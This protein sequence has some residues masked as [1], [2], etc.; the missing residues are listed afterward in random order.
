M[1]RN[2]SFRQPPNR[3]HGG[4]DIRKMQ[5]HQLERG[6]RYDIHTWHVDVNVGHISTYPT[7]RMQFFL[8]AGITYVM[9]AT[10]GIDCEFLTGIVD[11]HAT[12]HV[13]SDRND[14]DPHI[15][16]VTP[17]NGEPGASA[18]SVLAAMADPILQRTGQWIRNDAKNVVCQLCYIR[19]ES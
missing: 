6:W 2:R 3:K 8:L 11:D 5:V 18:N 1:S 13:Y 16:V 14:T 12:P 7:T 9:A 4:A 19:C 15:T 17:P 10:G